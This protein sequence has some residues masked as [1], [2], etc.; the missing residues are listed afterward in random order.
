MPPKD[1]D[2]RKSYNKNYQRKR[3]AKEK[4]QA[5]AGGSKPKRALSLVKPRANP[6]QADPLADALAVLEREQQEELAD[7]L[8]LADGDAEAEGEIRDSV[9]ADFS[10]FRI[11]ETLALLNPADP[12]QRQELAQGLQALF[13]VIATQAV[14]LSSLEGR[15]RQLEFQANGETNEGEHHG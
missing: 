9:Q 15:V 1:P 2:K 11:R 12:A 3:R 4:I 7:L 6:S 8:P 14:S 10:F 13:L 5:M